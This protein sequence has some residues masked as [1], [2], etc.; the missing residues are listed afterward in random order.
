VSLIFDPAGNIYGTTT[1]G[2]TYDNGTTFELTPSSGGYA[3]SILHSFG[4]DHDGAYPEAGVILDAAGNVYGTTGAGGTGR[5]C[6]YGCGTAYQLVPSGGSWLENILVS[7]DL[8]S[9]G[10]AG[11]YYPYS[12]LVMDGSGNLYGTTIYST[13]NDLDGIVY[14]LAPSGGGFVPS[15]FY[16]FLS[17]CQPY[18]G[19]TMDS[20]GNFFG[21]CTVGSPGVF[22][23]TNCSE[24]CT[25]VDLHDFDY[26]DGDS[27][28]G[29]PVLDA[30]GNLYGT[31]TYG[32]VEGNCN[33]GCGVVWEIAGVGAPRK[34]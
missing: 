22:E 28:Y 2:G 8:G 32:G 33:L 16:P 20:A 29:A 13:S 4:H 24:T 31:T 3:E 7:F 12:P 34:E 18:G 19:V 30:D 9:A 11:A 14:K 1:N 10:L 25:L 26:E 23:L 5:G 15:V 21:V 17:S 6:D 27:P